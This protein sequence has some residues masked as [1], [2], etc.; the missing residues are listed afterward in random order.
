MY[1]I[2]ENNVASDLVLE[3]TPVRYHF[4]KCFSIIKIFTSLNVKIFL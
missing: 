3:I 2:D 1:Q 4:M